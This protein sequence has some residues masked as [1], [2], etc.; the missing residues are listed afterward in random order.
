MLGLVC[1]GSKL[2]VPVVS[3]TCEDERAVAV[4]STLPPLASSVSTGAGQAQ[5]LGS[6]SRLYSLQYASKLT[7]DN[8]WHAAHDGF[9]RSH[10]LCLLRQ[11]KQPD[12]E[13]STLRRL[14]GP[15]RVKSS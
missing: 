6:A 11:V 8:L 14:R 13:R 12:L 5:S 10:N 1:S 9:P 3:R 2:A 4:D 15:Y 7:K